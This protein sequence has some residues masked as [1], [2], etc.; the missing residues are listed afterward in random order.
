MASPALSKN[1]LAAM[2]PGGLY[3]GRL[4]SKSS[5]FPM[6]AGRTIGTVVCVDAGIGFDVAVVAE[7]VAFREATVVTVVGAADRRVVAVL[8]VVGVAL[9][10]ATVVVEVI[11]WRSSCRGSS[12]AISSPSV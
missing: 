9:A 12:L 8:P 6:R 1:P 5:Q 4:L 3:G 10:A 11:G 2:L 7:L